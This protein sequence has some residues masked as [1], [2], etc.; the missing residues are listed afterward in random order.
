MLSRIEARHIKSVSLALVL[1][2]VG[3]AASYVAS[4]PVQ[5]WENNKQIHPAGFSA[6]DHGW[7][8]PYFHYACF[9]FPKPT[10][11]YYLDGWALALNIGTWAV[12]FALCWMVFKRVWHH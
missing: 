4:K 9:P 6:F 7:P 10:C 1:G 8:L 2:A 11:S 12:V 3:S 5:V